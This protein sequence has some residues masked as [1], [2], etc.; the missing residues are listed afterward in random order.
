MPS[1]E[2]WGFE[3]AG[4]CGTGG[5][6]YVQAQTSTHTSGCGPLPHTLEQI[7]VCDYFVPTITNE[8]GCPQKVTSEAEGFFQ[9]IPTWNIIDG[10]G[11]NIGTI[12]GTGPVGWA[13]GA[14]PQTTEAGCV[15]PYIDS[16]QKC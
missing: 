6:S 9:V 3:G 4:G 13:G 14:H 5:V 12:Q 2:V 7:D 15:S 8:D 10:D 11:N 1:Y 16:V